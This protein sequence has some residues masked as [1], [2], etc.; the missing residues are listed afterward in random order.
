MSVLIG[1]GEEDTAISSRTKDE[2]FDVTKTT[3][4]VEPRGPALVE[5]SAPSVVRDA[6]THQEHGS[7]DSRKS[8]LLVGV[9]LVLSV[10]AGLC[11]FLFLRS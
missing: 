9:S 7:G 11:A 4:N 2:A 8:V 10:L 6:L 3:P 1:D 5:I